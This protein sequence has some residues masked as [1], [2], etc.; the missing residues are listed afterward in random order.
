MTRMRSRWSAGL[1][2]VVRPGERD[3]YVSALPGSVRLPGDER[4][5]VYPLGVPLRGQ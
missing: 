5:E 2:L 3:R 1:K 4:P